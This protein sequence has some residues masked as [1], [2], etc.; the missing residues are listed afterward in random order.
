MFVFDL[1]RSER[2]PITARWMHNDSPYGGDGRLIR[3]PVQVIPQ[4][5]NTRCAAVVRRALARGEQSRFVRDGESRPV[6]TIPRRRA[7]ASGPLP[8]VLFVRTCDDRPLVDRGVRA[9]A[10]G[11]RNVIAGNRRGAT[12]VVAQLPG[13][14][15]EDGH[16]AAFQT[17]EP[18][19]LDCFFRQSLAAVHPAIVG[20][21]THCG[22]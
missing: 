13:D 9:I 14:T 22:D 21:G 20:P 1:D 5:A 18:R 11:L 15:L 6:V 10:G 3:V 17:A 4:R 12:A 19:R 16:E 8:T 7:T 2:A